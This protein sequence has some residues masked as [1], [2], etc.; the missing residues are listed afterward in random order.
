[1][2]ISSIER[3]WAVRLAAQQWLDQ[4]QAAG[5]EIWSQPEL[6]NFRFGGERISLMDVQRG[7]RI[8]AGWSAALSMRTVY[9]TPGADRPY[10][11][12]VGPEGL[13]R[14][15]WRGDDP[16]HAE[17]RGLRNAMDQNLPLIWF[18]PFATGKYV[19]LYP[20]YLLDEERSEHRFV[21]ALGEEQRIVPVRDASEVER[22][23][24]ERIT[25]QR[26]HQRAFQAG[27]LW[28]YDERCA[29]CSLHHRPLL[30]AAHITPDSDERGAPITSNGLALCKIHHAAFDSGI[31]GIR[32]N[33]T[34][35]IRDDIL[36]ETDG[37][38]LKH[39]LQEHHDKKLLVLPHVRRDRPDLERIT[40]R[41][42]LFLAR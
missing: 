33:L 21:V 42:E 35:H 41:Y 15:M 29:V 5:H 3:Q 38:M 25:R 6:A 10:D 32:P 16:D 36:R 39:G 19:P 31:L 8:P 11:D 2:A 9:R 34:V 7:I 40:E 4:E 37:P 14:Y 17:N 27:V 28:A 12:G 1:V 24:A 13:Y 30:D 22:R 26:L 18:F 23:Y 20:V